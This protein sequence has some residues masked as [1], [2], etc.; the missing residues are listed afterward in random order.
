MATSFS[1][2]PP[3]LLPHQ[4]WRPGRCPGLRRTLRLLQ[5]L[6]RAARAALALGLLPALNGFLHFL[7]LRLP[8]LAALLL[9]CAEQPHAPEEDAD[10]PTA[11]EDVIR[12]AGESEAPL[13]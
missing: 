3:P 11:G 10:C 4:S 7:L 13:A 12:P 9:L 1:T 5:K 2:P 6:R 8:L